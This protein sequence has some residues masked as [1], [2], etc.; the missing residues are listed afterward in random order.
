M[1]IRKIF[2]AG[3]RLISTLGS[4]IK[5]AGPPPRATD[6]PGTPDHQRIATKSGALVFPANDLLSLPEP[7][8]TGI[9]FKDHLRPETF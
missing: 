4:G 1:G 6:S 8:R 9:T 2:V 3:V 7:R 5:K